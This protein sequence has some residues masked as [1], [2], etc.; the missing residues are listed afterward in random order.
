LPPPPVQNVDVEPNFASIQ[1]NVLEPYCVKCHQ[2]RPEQGKGPAAG[3]D[4][5]TY[6]LL[7]ASQNDEDGSYP[8]V[9][10]QPDQSSLVEVFQKGTMPKPKTAARLSKNVAEAVALWIKNGAAR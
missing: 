7:M 6:D 10:G 8:V 1:K 5:R 2:P 4:L 9:V 3:I